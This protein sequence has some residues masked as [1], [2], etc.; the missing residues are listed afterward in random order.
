MKAREGKSGLSTART[1]VKTMRRMI[2]EHSIYLPQGK[3]LPPHELAIYIEATFASIYSKFKKELILAVPQE[4]NILM[5]AAREWKET[6]KV[7]HGI[8]LNLPI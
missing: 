6:M 2:L 1:M 3:D 8:E 7:F 5:Q 4:D